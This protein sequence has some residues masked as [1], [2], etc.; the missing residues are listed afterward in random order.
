M[1][2]SSERGLLCLRANQTHKDVVQRWIGL[3]EAAEANFVL[4]AK[5][6]NRLR[7]GVFAQ[8]EF[9]LPATILVSVAIFLHGA[10]G[11]YVSRLANG[12][13]VVFGIDPNTTRKNTLCFRDGA[14]E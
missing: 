14:V 7:I 8:L 5:L 1:H 6:K 4:A 3:V 12:R 13:N 9:P 10:D 11:K 2:I